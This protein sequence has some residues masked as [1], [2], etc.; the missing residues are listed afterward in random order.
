[1]VSSKKLIAFVLFS[2]IIGGCAAPRNLVI[3][4]SPIEDAV[5]SGRAVQSR[6]EQDADEGRP[7]VVHVVVCL[8]DNKY[9]WIQKTKNKK[10]GNGR[11]PSS[12]LYWGAQYGVR[13]YLL[14]NGWKK[15]ASY[16]G[17]KLPIGVLE[18]IIL[19][20]DSGRE[21]VYLVADAWDGRKIP[22]A[23]EH[24]LKI[25]GGHESEVITSRFKGHRIEFQAG[26][27]AHV[28]VYVGHNGLMDRTFLGH[29]LLMNM[30]IEKIAFVQ[31]APAK[32][33]IVLACKSREYFEKNLSRLGTHSLL[34]TEIKMAP[35][36]YTLNAVLRKW[37]SGNSAETVCEA[38]A[39]AYAKYQKINVNKAMG[40]FYCAP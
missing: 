5:P 8:A 9:Q 16:P 1:M 22:R 18:R 23:I 14:N 17:A 25:A 12:N 39:K 10:Q 7:L 40:Y 26:G 20:D 4:E 24:F 19:L 15:A 29:N 31:D 21:A 30:S 27:S 35:E 37:F 32:S 36:A 3:R 34:L 38:A 2:I 11:D 13:T 6:I 28:V 33:A